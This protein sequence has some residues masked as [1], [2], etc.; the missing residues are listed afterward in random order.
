M[1]I[2]QYQNYLKKFKVLI[3]EIRRNIN[4]SDK[5]GFLEYIGLLVNS[6]ELQISEII[7]N[8]IFKTDFTHNTISIL[9]DIM[10]KFK[11]LSEY[12]DY[13]IEMTEK[14]CKISFLRNMDV[15]ERS[16]DIELKIIKEIAEDHNPKISHA[17]NIQAWMYEKEF[18]KVLQ[19]IEKV[20][21][22]YEELKKNK[23]Q[24]KKLFQ[25][26]NDILKEIPDT[27]NSAITGE[28]CTVTSSP[29][30]HAILFLSKL[31][32]RGEHKKINGKVI[33]ELGCGLHNTIPYSIKQK[34]FPESNYIGVDAHPLISIL[35]YLSIK[36]PNKKTIIS[37]L[38]IHVNST[39]R[40]EGVIYDL[41][42][43]D[44][45]VYG[46]IFDIKI[47]KGTVGILIIDSTISLDNRGVDVTE[48]K[49][50]EMAEKYLNEGGYYIDRDFNYFTAFKLINGKLSRVASLKFD[51]T[52]YTKDPF[53]WYGEYEEF[54]NDEEFK[55]VESVE[56]SKEINKIYPRNIFN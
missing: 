39:E 42:R 34:Y 15:F 19:L 5:K 26:V 23:Y 40:E 21:I 33:L 48:S 13:K 30:K 17:M 46:S 25:E 18:D 1:D 20:I 56:E 49:A 38:L 55:D 28:V 44:T 43:L 31:I 54:N 35:R 9:L 52:Y 29:D 10:R 45:Y 3:Q 51:K 2:K 32:S 4:K 11:S 37:N 50:M 6:A 47:K 14:E 53:S 16:I 36:Y 41:A 27:P 7:S 8:H 12:Y 22:N 24:L